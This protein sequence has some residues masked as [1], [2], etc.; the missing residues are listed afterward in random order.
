MPLV[1]RPPLSSIERK[2]RQ[3]LSRDM[4]GRPAVADTARSLAA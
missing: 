2:V 3:A 1:L 4:Y